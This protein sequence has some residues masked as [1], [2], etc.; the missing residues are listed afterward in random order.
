MVDHPHCNVDED[1]KGSSFFPTLNLNKKIDDKR[2]SVD[3]L[4][5]NKRRNVCVRETFQPVWVMTHHQL[6]ASVKKVHDVKSD[7][8]RREED[9]GRK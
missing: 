7:F 9:R 2:F 3:S 8:K 4:F 6:K 1:M 5:T